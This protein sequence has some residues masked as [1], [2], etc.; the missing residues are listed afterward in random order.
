MKERGILFTKENRQKVRDGSKTQTRRVIINQ[1]SPIETVRFI[2]GDW[3]VGQEGYC[4]ADGQTNFQI[5]SILKSPYQV[6][7][8]LY[9]KE[10]YQI[11]EGDLDTHR[12]YG[13]YMDDNVRFNRPLDYKFDLWFN[14]K[15]RFRPTS[16]MFMYKSL[17]RLW[18]ETT[19]VRVEQVQDISEKD[20][21]AEGIECVGARHYKNYNYP[22]KTQNYYAAVLSAKTSFETLWDSINKKRGYGW[23]KNPWTFAYTFKR[24]EK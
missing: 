20:C 16:S 1:P 9:L 17:A 18:V 8:P 6:G 4:P 19:E 21:I 12:V 5:N 14:R 24:I 22:N 3:C 7:D 2:N 11:D 13:K 15:Y 10:P 23:D